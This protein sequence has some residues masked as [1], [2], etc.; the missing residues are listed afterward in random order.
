M[1]FP[2]APTCTGIYIFSFGIWYFLCAATITFIFFST[3]FSLLFVPYSSTSFST[4]GLGPTKLMSPFKM[5]IIWGSSS[6]LDFLKK[7]PIFVILG[8]F[9]N[10]CVFSNSSLASSLFSKYSFNFLSAPIHIDLNL[11]SLNTFPF[12]PYLN[13]S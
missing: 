13:C 5:F 3:C 4:T 11:Y 7:L 8:S 12:F 2:S 10:L 6:K 1:L 9:C